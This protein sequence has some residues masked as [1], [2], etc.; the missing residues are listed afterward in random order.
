MDWVVALDDGGARALDDGGALD[1]G[2]LTGGREVA[3]VAG[4]RVGAGA[5]SVSLA[6]TLAGSGN[7]S[8]GWPSRSRF[9]IAAQVAVG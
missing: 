1:V 2:W 8:I 9:M 4:G 5:W 6:G 3:C 7:F